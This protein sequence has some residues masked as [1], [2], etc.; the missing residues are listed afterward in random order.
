VNRTVAAL[1]GA[2]ASMGALP[3]FPVRNDRHRSESPEA[4]ARIQIAAVAKRARKRLARIKQAELTVLGRAYARACL[5]AR[6]QG[7]RTG[8]VR[9]LPAGLAWE[10]LDARRARS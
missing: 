6:V 7:R 8:W 3:P 9:L 4:Q 2:A 1:L 10:A 5:D